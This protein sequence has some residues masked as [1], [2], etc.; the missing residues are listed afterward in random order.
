MA[1]QQGP[2]RPSARVQRGPRAWR[3]RVRL[4]GVAVGG[5]DLLLFRR[6]PWPESHKREAAGKR[7]SPVNA[8]VLGVAN[9]ERARLTVS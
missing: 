6:A 3:C 4:R 2:V 9:V 8:W 7:Q 1:S 5:H